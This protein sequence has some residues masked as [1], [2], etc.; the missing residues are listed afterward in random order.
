MIC[1]PDYIYYSIEQI[2]ENMQ[3]ETTCHVRKK[4]YFN[5]IL[6][7]LFITCRQMYCY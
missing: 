1:N 6:V 5:A 2:P 3:F 7:E 4:N